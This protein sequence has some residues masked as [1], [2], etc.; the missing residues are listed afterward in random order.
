MVTNLSADNDNF[1]ARTSVFL[2]NIFNSSGCEYHQNNV[3]QSSPHYNT[4]EQ[5]SSNVPDYYFT[6]NELSFLANI[7]TA[8]HRHIHTS[9]DSP[10]AEHYTGTN[11]S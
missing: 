11:I 2:S 7:N 6:E 10:A 9:L 1:L 5:I 8:P 4:H 3:S